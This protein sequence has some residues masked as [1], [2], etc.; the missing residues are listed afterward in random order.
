MVPSQR[1]TLADYLVSCRRDLHQIPELHNDLPQTTAYV[2]KHLD[3]LQ[4]PYTVIKNGGI[5][6]MVGNPQKGK[7]FLLR[8]D[9]DA[10]PLNEES[11][12]PFSSCNGHMH[13]CGHDLHTAM[14]LGAA[15]LLKEQEKNLPGAVKLVFQYDEEGLTGMKTLVEHGV[16]ES[17]HVGGALAIHVFPGSTMVPG[18]YSC[19]PGPANSSVTEYRIEIT[20]RGSHG[21]TPFK[22]IDPINVGVQI[23]N[24]LLALVPKEVDG[25]DTA[26]ISNGYFCAGTPTAYNIVPSSVVMGGGI[27]TLDNT[28]AAYIRKRIE[29]IAACAAAAFHATCKV[30]FPASAPSCVNDQEV[31]RCVDEAGESLGMENL[32]MLPHL[33]SDDFSH[34]SV[35]VPSCYIWMGAGGTD[36]QHAGGVLH[37][38]KVR[39]SEDA[40]TYGTGLLVGTAVNWLNRQKTED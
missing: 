32:K 10:L 19:L 23:Y 24:M 40:L 16:L 4:V 6:A 12:E 13:A 38:P 37:D 14:L 21:A 20:G 2:I 8:G 7:T 26:V 36:E 9:M 35:C 33:S 22:G 25:R 27:R 39:F 34:V 29:E 17:P 30:T 5:V 18:T 3:E 11:G 31:C 15:K 1:D 28:T